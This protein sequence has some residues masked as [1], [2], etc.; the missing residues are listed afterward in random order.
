[1]NQLKGPTGLFTEHDD[2]NISIY[3]YI[4]DSGNHRIIKW[5]L[6]ASLHSP[7]VISINGSGQL[8]YLRHII[9]DKK[10]RSMFIYDKGNKIKELLFEKSITIKTVTITLNF[11][12]I[13]W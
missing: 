9:M 5:G 6:E 3:I 10:D 13:F 12:M 7:V 11:S 1:L 2:D 8:S 4:A